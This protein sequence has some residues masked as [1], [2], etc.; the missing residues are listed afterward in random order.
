MAQVRLRFKRT[1]LQ[2]LDRIVLAARL[3]HQYAVFLQQQDA[4]LR[5]GIFNQQQHQFFQQLIELN[6]TLQGL[7]CLDHGFDIDALFGR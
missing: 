2:H 3:Q 4:F 6:F 7:R 1:A 5:T